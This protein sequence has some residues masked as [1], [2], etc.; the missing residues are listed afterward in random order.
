MGISLLLKKEGISNIRK[1][2]T[3]N[4]NKI[5]SFISEKICQSFP[6]LHLSQSELFIQISRLDMYIASM[7]DNASA[8]YVYGKN[9]IYFNEKLNLNKMDVTAI[10]E[11]IH[12]LQEFKDEKG[13][14]SK[15]GLYDLNSATGLALNEAAVQL[16]ACRMAG[17]VDFDNVTYYGMSF[18]SESPEF[19][20]LECALVSQMTF[21]TGDEA[22]YFSTLYSSQMFERAFISDSTPDTFYNVEI[23]LDKLLHLENELSRL[24]QKLQISEASGDKSKLLQHQIE[25]KKRNITS[26]CLKIQNMIIENC[27]K[28]RFVKIDTFDDIR[29]FEKDLI[30]FR[31]YLILPENY[32]FYDDFCKKMMDDISFKKNQIIKY[33]RIIDIPKEYGEFLPMEITV[34]KMSKVRE[35]ILTL[36]EFIFGE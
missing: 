26:V 23:E 32:S 2:D 29:E 11:C 30:E 15:L 24:S 22:L 34:K 12:Y 7:D 10:H 1:L 6:E 36:K 5:A 31:K 16:I 20:P 9:A 21:F 25:S 14:L 19:Y 33:G 17:D 28:K 18:I 3:M 13:N 27:F 4:I 8:K 35:I